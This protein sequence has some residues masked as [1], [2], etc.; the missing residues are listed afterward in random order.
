VEVPYKVS[1]EQ[2]RQR[3]VLDKEDIQLVAKLIQGLDLVEASFQKAINSYSA[4]PSF[5]NSAI[6][7]KF[8]L[9]PFVTQNE[10]A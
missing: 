9:K 8:S 2:I 3:L 1:M 7:A 10:A 6:A 5:N 4:V